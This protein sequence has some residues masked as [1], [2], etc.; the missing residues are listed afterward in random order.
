MTCSQK[1]VRRFTIPEHHWQLE[2]PKGKSTTGKLGLKVLA[3]A[4][5][6]YGSQLHAVQM[7]AHI[8]SVSLN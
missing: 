1:Q 2:K 3:M 5:K 7:F 6:A 4:I 8:Y